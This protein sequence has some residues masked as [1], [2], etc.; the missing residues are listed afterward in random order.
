MLLL[1]YDGVA[2]RCVVRIFSLEHYIHLHIHIAERAPSWPKLK[3]YC[4]TEQE[5]LYHRHS[6]IPSICSLTPPDP[7]AHLYNTNPAATMMSLRAIARAAPRTASRFACSSTTATLRPAFQSALRLRT[8]IQIPRCFATSVPRFDDISQELAA[9]LNQEMQLESEENSAPADSD[10][11][12]ET[13]KNQNPHWDIIDESGAQ[14]VLLKRK[15]DDEDITVSFSIVDF[16]TPMMENEDADEA[17]MDEED[18]AIM[19]G[20]SGGGNTKGAINQGRTSGGNIKVAPEDSIA[21]GDHE[22]LR[23]E[24]DEVD[25]QAAFPANVNVLVQ[26]KAKVCPS[27]IN[28]TSSHLLLTC[29]ASRV[30]SAST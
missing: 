8:S 2:A 5:V 11:N 18:E 14:E 29:S 24:E 9:K 27:P 15:Y 22:E 28:T 23:S 19:E 20:Q 1:Q 4:F 10:S 12:I 17:M 13:F 6:S 7:I 25:G 16:N 21:P 26:R 30:P 3:N